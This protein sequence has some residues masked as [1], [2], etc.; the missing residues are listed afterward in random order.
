MLAAGD[1]A[2]TGLILILDIDCER[3]CSMLIGPLLARGPWSGRGGDAGR[4][5]LADRQPLDAAAAARKQPSDG[6]DRVA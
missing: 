5:P 3:D 4:L 2:V 1:A 6:A